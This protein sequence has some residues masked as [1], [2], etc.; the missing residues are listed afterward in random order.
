[1]AWVGQGALGNT[2]YKACILVIGSMALQSKYSTVVIYIWIHSK[3]SLA[4]YVHASLGYLRRSSLSPEKLRCP[5]RLALPCRARMAFD[6]L[7]I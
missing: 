3:L 6:M 2:Y 4:F 1:M 5:E 7:E